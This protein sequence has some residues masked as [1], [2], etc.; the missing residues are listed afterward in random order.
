MWHQWVRNKEALSAQK[1][2]IGEIIFL[3]FH[4]HPGDLQLLSV[5]ETG[6]VSGQYYQE[7]FS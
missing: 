2:L 3:F 4:S 1:F 5:T 7:C 6:L